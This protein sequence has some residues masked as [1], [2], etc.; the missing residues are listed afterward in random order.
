MVKPWTRLLAFLVGAWAL[1][2]LPAEAACTQSRIEVLPRSLV[3]GPS[4]P[5]TWQITPPCD[6]IETGIL[7]GTDP[8]ALDPAGERIYGLRSAYQQVVGVSETRAYWIAAYALDEEGNLIHS[9]PR[10]VPVL[11]PPARLGPRGPHGSHGAPP[12]YTGTDADF[13]KQ[14]GEPHFASLRRFD[15]LERGQ[16]SEEGTFIVSRFATGVDHLVGST[17]PDEVLAGEAQAVTVGGL[18]FAPN[19]ADV[20]QQID[21][22]TQN[23]IIFEHPRPGFYVVRCHLGKTLFPDFGTSTEVSQCF[24]EPRVFRRDFGGLGFVF[25]DGFSRLESF[26]FR[27]FFSDSTSTS[28]T[29]F[30]PGAS[31]ESRLLSAKLRLG[32]FVL[33]D[34][35]LVRVSGKP[36]ERL[37]E[38][39]CRPFFGD[40]NV[41]TAFGTWDFTEEAAGLAGRGG[42]ELGLTADP[43]PSFLL[44]DFPPPVLLQSRSAFWSGQLDVNYPWSHGGEIGALT[45]SFQQA[46]PRE[47]RVT[48]TPNRVRPQLPIGTPLTGDLAETVTRA[49]VDALVTSCSPNGGAP[50]SVDVTFRVKAPSPGSQEAGGHDHDTERPKGTFERRPKEGGLQEA[51]CLVVLDGQGMGK[52]LVPVTYHPDEV[53]GTETIEATAT[54][55]GQATT[56][57]TVEVPGL[58][59]LPEDPTRYELVGAPDNHAGTN[60]PCRPARPTSKHFQ[61]HFGTRRLITAVR[62]VADRMLRE[63]GILLRVN[64]MSLP[65]GGLFDIDNNWI[66]PHDGHRVGL[67]VDIGVQGIRNRACPQYD[68]LQLQRAIFQATRKL[69]KL[70]LD[71]RGNPTH[72]HGSIP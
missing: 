13:L 55:F 33:G 22:L 9:A 17:H 67:E 31:P 40:V 16:E 45:L 71:K 60:D 44:Q 4:I 52:C 58:E 62:E 42:G 37:D 46:C 27:Q 38:V 68:L 41:C 50:A 21:A 1:G 51:H 72:F 11:I 57:V 61:N 53:S 19:P 14:A 10:L 18:S 6:V 48:V 25:R 35:A 47:L 15:Q 54:G 5:V 32:L 30:I 39:S 70:E 49:T 8:S 3:I 69:P 43:T 63:T 7:L 29:Y 66:S 28:A 59:P 24:Q 56:N 20:S 12:S 26:A 2:P 36:A 34:P 65:L 23:F 64:D